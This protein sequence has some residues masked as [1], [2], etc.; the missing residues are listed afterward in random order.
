MN[1][2]ARAE[3]GTRNLSSLVSVDFSVVLHQNYVFCSGVSFVSRK[4]ARVRYEAA[5][6]G[7]YFVMVESID[8]VGDFSFIVSIDRAGDEGGGGGMDEGGGGGNSRGQNSDF[9]VV[10]PVWSQ[11]VDRDGVS[12]LRFSL[13]FGAIALIKACPPARPRL[14]DPAGGGAGEVT[15]VTMP[16]TRAYF[17]DSV[18]RLFRNRETLKLERRATAGFSTCPKSPSSQD[19]RPSDHHQ[20]TDSK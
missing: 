8:D 4:Y 10:R 1:P 3:A 18:L 14:R 11:D 19:D 13:R 6:P 16:R 2:T 12:S 9:P 5:S 7:T 20:K 17:R 15:Q